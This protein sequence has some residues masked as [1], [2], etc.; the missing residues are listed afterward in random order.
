M[1]GNQRTLLQ[2]ILAEY[3]N[4]LP[5]EMAQ[6]RLDRIKKAG[7]QS[8]LRLGRRRKQRRA[9]LLPRA[10]SRLSDRVR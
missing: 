4:N 3:A 5:Q 2:N 10:G 8:L 7:T 6:E 9:A 1:N